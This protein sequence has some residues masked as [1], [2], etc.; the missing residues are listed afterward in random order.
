MQGQNPDL[1]QY[2]HVYVGAFVFAF[3]VVIPAGNL[4]LVGPATKC[5]ARSGKKQIPCGNDN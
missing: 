5:Y 3:L 4:L 2:C 1:Y